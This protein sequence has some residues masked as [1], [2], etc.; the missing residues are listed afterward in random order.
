MRD[1][2]F[3]VAVRV[4]I[5]SMFAGASVFIYFARSI[6]WLGVIGGALAVLGILVLTMSIVVKRSI[7]DVFNDEITGDDE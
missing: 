6:W 2:T 4:G 1:Q 5:A 3:Y 7:S